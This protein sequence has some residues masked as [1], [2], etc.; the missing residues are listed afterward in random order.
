MIARI[1]R[2]RVKPGKLEEYRKIVEASGESDYKATPGNLGAWIL[3]RDRGEYGE[4]VTLSFWE[5][6]DA[7][8]GFAGE[9]IN[10][11]RYYSGDEDYLLEMNEE[12]EHY[13]A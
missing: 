6:R 2:G 11:A 9:D 1:W 12:V 4:I 10:L 13:D 8:K 5:S 3:T 7:I